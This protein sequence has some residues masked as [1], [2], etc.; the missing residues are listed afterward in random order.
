MLSAIPKKEFSSG[1]GGLMLKSIGSAARE[2]M[3]KLIAG[4]VYLELFVKVQPKWRQS[5]T[6]LS[7]LGYKV[8]N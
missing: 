6:V 8:E 5:R 2:Q 1:K 3:Q 4:K 7:D